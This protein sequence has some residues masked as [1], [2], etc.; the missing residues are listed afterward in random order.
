M[1]YKRVL[2][3][4]LSSELLDV[5]SE[6]RRVVEKAVRK[7]TD[8]EETVADMVTIF[9]EAVSN[10]M[11]HAYGGKEGPVKVALYVDPQ[12]RKFVL[13]VY[14]RGSIPEGMRRDLSRYT[15]NVAEW[16]ERGQVGGIGLHLIARLSDAVYWR[17]IKNGKYLQVEKRF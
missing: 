12:K 15:V 17:K 7:F 10:A 4:G 6:V 3:I 5:L 9:D 1:A 2:S 13:R 11:K 14:D 8:D 16:L